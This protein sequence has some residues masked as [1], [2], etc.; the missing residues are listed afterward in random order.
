M[1]RLRTLVPMVR[2]ANG[3]VEN[4]LTVT[5]RMRR[6]YIKKISIPLYHLYRICTYV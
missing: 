4:N 3:K 2:T 6:M 5:M 1:R